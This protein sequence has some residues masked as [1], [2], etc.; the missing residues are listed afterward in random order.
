[1]SVKCALLNPDR[2]YPGKQ[3]FDYFEGVSESAGSR[4]L[5]VH[6]LPTPPGERDKLHV[7]ARHETAIYMASPISAFGMASTL[8]ITLPSRKA[9]FLHPCG[10]SAFAD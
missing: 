4:G 5:Y 7:H 2:S 6:L 1:M 3:G 10:R 8:S 9:I